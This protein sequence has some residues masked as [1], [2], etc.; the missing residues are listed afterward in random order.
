MRPSHRRSVLNRAGDFSDLERA[1]LPLLKAL[2]KAQT[3]ADN[4][5]QKLRKFSN[6]AVPAE[7]LSRL[8][9]TVTQ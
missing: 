8:L 5:L 6:P 7:H 2:P 1:V 3:I 9:Q 4:A